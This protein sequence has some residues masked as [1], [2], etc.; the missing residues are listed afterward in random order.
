MSIIGSIISILKENKRSRQIFT[1]LALI[2]IL[3]AFGLLMAWNSPSPEPEPVM[4][5]PPTQTPT[6]EPEWLPTPTPTAVT[7]KQ[8]VEINNTIVEAEWDVC[9]VRHN[10]SW[11]YAHRCGMYASSGGS[12]GSS[13]PTLPPS[14]VPELRAF[15]MLLIGLVGIWLIAV[16]QRK[17]Q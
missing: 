17:N 5:V 3:G 4:I 11:L 12:S 6:P 15:S 16:R 14:P 8:A 13:S 1:L 2:G 10:E 9:D 7:P